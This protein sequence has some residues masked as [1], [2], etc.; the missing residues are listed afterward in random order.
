MFLRVKY[1]YLYK[2]KIKLQ[3][4]PTATATCGVGGCHLCAAASGG[5]RVSAGRCWRVFVLRLILCVANCLVCAAFLSC[6]I[7]FSACFLFLRGFL[8]VVI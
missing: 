8:S 3:V 5:E 6:A 7:V 2:A 1:G 4:L